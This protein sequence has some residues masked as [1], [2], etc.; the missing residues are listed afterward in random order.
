M[1]ND[2]SEGQQM[3]ATGGKVNETMSG[4]L[5]VGTD[6]LQ[7]I[8]SYQRPWPIWNLRLTS[9]AWRTAARAVL[10]RIVV[11]SCTIDDVRRIVDVCP[12]LQ[13]ILL[14]KSEY[15][16]YAQTVPKFEVFYRI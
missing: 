14:P 4:E 16:P 5:Y 13:R 6:A 1:V 15:F 9:R 7:H 12:N 8:L 2:F 11:G 10:N 3:W